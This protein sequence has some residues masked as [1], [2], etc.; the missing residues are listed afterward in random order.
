MRAA[1]ELANQIGMERIERRTGNGDFIL[2]RW[3]AW[4]GSWTSPDR[5]A[6]AIASVN[7]A[8]IQITD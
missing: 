8:P 2:K 1:V 7:V 6:R 5:R 4:R 3:S